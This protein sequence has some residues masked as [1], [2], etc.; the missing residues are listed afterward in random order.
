M[1]LACGL[2]LDPEDLRVKYNQYA[3]A[4]AAFPKPGKV[5]SCPE[6]LRAGL[7]YFQFVKVKAG[8]MIEPYANC[9]QRPGFVVAGGQTY[10]EAMHNAQAGAAE[11]ADRIVTK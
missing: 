4:W 9:A 10:S 2:P 1:S 11:L 8:D 5:V 7:S 6:N 3:A